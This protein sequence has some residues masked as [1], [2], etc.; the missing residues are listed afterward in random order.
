MVDNLRKAGAVPVK[1][2]GKIDKPALRV[3]YKLQELGEPTL[4]DLLAEYGI[5]G[6]EAALV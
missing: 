6:T 2:T 3:T 4:A 5:I 1:A